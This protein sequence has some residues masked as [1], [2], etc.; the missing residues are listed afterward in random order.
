MPG[1]MGSLLPLQKRADTCVIAKHILRDEES[2]DLLC[3]IKAKSVTVAEVW[4][5]GLA[6]LEEASLIGP[7]LKSNIQRDVHC[8]ELSKPRALAAPQHVWGLWVGAGLRG[9]TTDKL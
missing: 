4:F 2:L 8:V 1:D 7:P 5:P 3:E 6:I 9:I